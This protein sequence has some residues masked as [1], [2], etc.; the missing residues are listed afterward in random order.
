M[1]T[2]EFRIYDMNTLYKLDDLK[3]NDKCLC[4]CGASLAMGRTWP[5]L[6]SR[7]CPWQTISKYH[8]TASFKMQEKKLTM[9]YIEAHTPFVIKI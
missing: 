3:Y 2:E 6:S 5:D 7:T 1:N 4:K 9:F 8:L